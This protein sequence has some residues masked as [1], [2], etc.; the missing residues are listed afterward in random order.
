MITKKIK[1]LINRSIFIFMLLQFL[2]CISGV[3]TMYMQITLLDVTVIE[4]KRVLYYY[5]KSS[6]FN[7]NYMTLL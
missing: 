2:V 1:T 4:E 6:S 3:E 7:Y 5:K